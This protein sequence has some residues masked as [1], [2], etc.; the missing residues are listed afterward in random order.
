MVGGKWVLVEEELALISREIKLKEVLVREGIEIRSLGRLVQGIIEPNV[1]LHRCPRGSK[2]TNLVKLKAKRPDFP[3]LCA[4]VS[5][6]PA[7]NMFGQ[8]VYHLGVI[9]P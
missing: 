2:A 3:A 7:I 4:L 5:D 6:F 9:L 8:F 1:I